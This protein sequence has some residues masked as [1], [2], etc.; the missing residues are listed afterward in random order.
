MSRNVERRPAG[1]SGAPSTQRDIDMTSAS[2]TGCGQGSGPVDDDAAIRAVLAADD[3]HLRRVLAVDADMRATL[4]YAPGDP[5]A[6]R[7]R[8]LVAVAR[9]ETRRRRVVRRRPTLRIEGE[10]A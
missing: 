1:H 7:L 10:S 5:D 3:E 2:G 4:R 9:V 6:E 8:T